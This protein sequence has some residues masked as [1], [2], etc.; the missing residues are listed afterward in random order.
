MNRL[1]YFLWIISIFLFSCQQLKHQEEKLVIGVMAS[2][3]FVPVAVA[4]KMG[5]FEKYGVNVAIEKFYSANERDAAFQGGI[6]DGT[7]IDYTGAILQK[8]GGAD[9]KLTSACNAP[10]CIMSGPSGDVKQLQDL[11]GKKIAI[12]QNTVIDFCM[13]MALQSVRLTPQEVEKQEINK[14]PVRFEMMMSGKTDATALP[15]PFI[16]IA[17]DKGANQIASMYDLGYVVTGIMFKGESLKNKEKQI[18]AF[19]DAY[20]EAVVYIRNHTIEDIRNV[21]I[22]DVG[23]PPELISKVQLPVYVPAQLPAEKD[24]R[25]VIQW[26]QEK[27]LI[28]ENFNRE[29]LIDV[30][31]VRAEK[32]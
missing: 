17:K 16:T 4:Q 24:I 23:F 22:Q 13:D 21:L 5:Y 31:F 11:K 26:L 14:I 2:M 6:I 25:A 29:E 28:P 30:R 10:F 20:N 12:S 1:L 3:D 8:S 9:L 27:K 19:Y 15:D 32:E 18:Q 7:V